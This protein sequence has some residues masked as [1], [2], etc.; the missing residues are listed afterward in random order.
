M[1][2]IPNAESRKDEVVAN[3]I[4]SWVDPKTSSLCFIFIFVSNS[5]VQ[6]NVEA[7]ETGAKV[8]STSIDYLIPSIWDKIELKNAIKAQKIRTHDKMS[9][10][11]F[12][13]NDLLTPKDRLQMSPHRLARLYQTLNYCTNIPVNLN[14]NTN[15]YIL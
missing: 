10:M 14:S 6:C 12:P 8:P 4:R 11:E 7:L 15:M 13:K 1:R 2:T 5:L 3:F 9:R